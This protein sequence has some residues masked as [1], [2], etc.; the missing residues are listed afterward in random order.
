MNN[1]YEWNLLHDKRRPPKHTKHLNIHYSTIL[2]GCIN[3]WNSK[4]KLKQFQILLDNA[5]GSTIVMRNIIEIINTK[6][7]AVMQWN[8][9]AVSINTNLKVKMWFTLPELSATKIVTC[10]C[11]VNDAAKGRYD[12]ILGIYL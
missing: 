8:T 10:N 3:T 4:A 9:Q 11:H 6:R 2:H 7:D 12:M 1:I 5:C